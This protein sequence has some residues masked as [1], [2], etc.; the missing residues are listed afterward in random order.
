MALFI[1]RILYFSLVLHVISSSLTIAFQYPSLELPDL[2][3]TCELE[4]K[5][6]GTCKH[7]YNCPSAVKG[8]KKKKYP[9]TCSFDGF[10]PIVCCLGDKKI[11]KNAD[12]HGNPSFGKVSAEMC[13]NYSG[14]VFQ[15]HSSPTLLPGVLFEIEDTCAIKQENYKESTVLAREF[16]HLA[17]I[18][19]DLAGDWAIYEMW[20]CGGALISEKYVLTAATCH[21]LPPLGLAKYVRVGSTSVRENFYNEK[22]LQY[23]EI[24]QFIK[25]PK[26]NL[27]RLLHNIALVKLNDSVQ[28]T[29]IVRPACLGINKV[30]PSEAINVGWGTLNTNTFMNN[31]PLKNLMTI[32]DRESCSNIRK[33]QFCVKQVPGTVWQ[34]CLADQ[35][36]PLQVYTDGH[37]CT[38]NIIGVLSSW[39][40]CSMSSRGTYVNVTTYIPWIETT[41]WGQ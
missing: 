25:H 39:D 5:T 24:N 29:S 11:D 6:T 23:F 2:D 3:E 21:H 12:E 9:K 36:S 22:P 26:F 8:L 35:G 32:V 27:L 20:K 28:F 10:N 33:K 40:S 30:R 18:G 34:N 7:I 15:N 14:L 4:D 38:Y 13:K 31:E 37:Y 1:V 17:S 19:Y 41:V 16:P